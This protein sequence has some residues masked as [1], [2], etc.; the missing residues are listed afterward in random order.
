ML[1]AIKGAPR[2]PGSSLVRRRPA[3]F[4]AETKALNALS[5]GPAGSGPQGLPPSPA[6]SG[7]SPARSD[8][9]TQELTRQLAEQ[10]KSSDIASSS[11]PVLRQGA[12]VHLRDA[13]PDTCA[14]ARGTRYLRTTRERARLD[15]MSSQLCTRFPRITRVR[16]RP[17]ECGPPWPKPTRANVFDLSKVQLAAQGTSSPKAGERVE[18]GHT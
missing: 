17:V 6:L 16:A 4:N 15:T 8:H 12:A 11:V 18:P 7:P 1:R 5:D 2:P 10:P 14:R 13:Q 3:G 9:S